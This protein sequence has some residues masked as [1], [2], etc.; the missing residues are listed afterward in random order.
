MRD[1]GRQ[2]PPRVLRL[3]DDIERHHRKKVFLLR[4]VV[5]S[6]VVPMWQV[7]IGRGANWK[8]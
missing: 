2:N 4:W 7:M 8:D 1:C 5:I 3:P 6:D